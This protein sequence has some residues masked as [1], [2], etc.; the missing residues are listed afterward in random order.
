MRTAEGKIINER[1]PDWVQLIVFIITALFFAGVV[2]ATVSNNEK[3][4]C[5]VEEKCQKIDVLITEVAWIKDTMKKVYNL[6]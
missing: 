5:V 2:F 4:I 3:R 6:R 1:R